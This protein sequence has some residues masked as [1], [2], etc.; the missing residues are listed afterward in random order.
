MTSDLFISVLALL[1]APPVLLAVYGLGWDAGYV[2]GKLQ[3]VVG[4]KRK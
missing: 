1:V 4:R 3:K 2:T